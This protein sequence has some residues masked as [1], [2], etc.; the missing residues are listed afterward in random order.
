MDAAQKLLKDSSS[1]PGLKSVTSG[2]TMSFTVQPGEF[3]QILHTGN[4]HWV[5][6]STVGVPHPVVRVYDG[7]FSSAGSSLEGQIACTRN[8]SMF[9]DFIDVPIQA[10]KIM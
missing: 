3:V 8:E 7:M 9:I 1:V 2:L 10:G 4:G 6:T 5:T